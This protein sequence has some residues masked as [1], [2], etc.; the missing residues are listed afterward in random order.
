MFCEPTLAMAS[1][2][3][4]VK[5]P[6]RVEGRHV[7]AAVRSQWWLSAHL[8]AIGT[9][10]AFL[11]GVVRVRGGSGRILPQVVRGGLDAG[12]SRDLPYDVAESAV[13]EPFPAA[14]EEHRPL[15]RLDAARLVSQASIAVR[16]SG[17]RPGTVRYTPPLPVPE[18]M[19]LQRRADRTMSSRLSAASSDI[20]NPEKDSVSAIAVSRV[21]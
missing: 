15:G 4:R 20:R 2:R 8:I 16:A 19:I 9:P 5:R 11:L 7:H 13:A 1:C 18:M 6:V 10:A 21:D 17:C 3:R 12:V 14:A